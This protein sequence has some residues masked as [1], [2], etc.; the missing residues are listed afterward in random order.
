MSADYPMPAVSSLRTSRE[1]NK[2]DC[3]ICEKEEKEEGTCADHK[4]ELAMKQ[5]CHPNA[6]VTAIYFKERDIMALY[7]AHCHKPIMG[8]EVM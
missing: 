3:I 2:M 7:C 6:D 5:K 1:L 4:G 8:V